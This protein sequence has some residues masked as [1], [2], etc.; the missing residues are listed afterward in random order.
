MIFC[1]ENGSISFEF[2]SYANFSQNLFDAENSV[3]IL[4]SYD[5][6]E[7]GWGV[8]SSEYFFTYDISTLSDGCEDILFS[9]KSSFEFTG[10]F[11]YK[12][13]CDLDYYYKFVIKKLNDNYSVMLEI[14]DGLCEYISV[15]EIMDDIK[16]KKICDE[17]RE[18]KIKFPVVKK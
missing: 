12:I 16:Y 5:V 13:N 7:V 14:Y 15:T 2:I 3:E 10:N 6:E 11:P 9:R 1:D 18:A 8:G 17:L 4:F